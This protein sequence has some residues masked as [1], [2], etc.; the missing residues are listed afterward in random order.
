MDKYH[1]SELI[2]RARGRKNS[3]ISYLLT[4]LN[5]TSN[6]PQWGLVHELVL[7]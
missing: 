7:Y 4:R 2:K 5:D 6:D 1:I 3:S